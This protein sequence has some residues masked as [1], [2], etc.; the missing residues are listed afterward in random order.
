MRNSFHLLCLMT[1][2]D[3]SSFTLLSQ[4][5]SGLA[6]TRFNVE[7]VGPLIVT[8]EFVSV[9]VS[10]LVIQS[11]SDSENRLLLSGRKEIPL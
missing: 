7:T 2:V 5:G 9:S 6:W 10:V 11:V 8:Q 4:G 3:Y 1:P